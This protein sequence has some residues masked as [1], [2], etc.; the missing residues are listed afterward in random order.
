MDE[1]FETFF[2]TDRRRLIASLCAMGS[3][4]DTATEAVDEAFARAIERWSR[5]GSYTSASAWVFVTARNLVRR[6][7]R[8]RAHERRL[9]AAV[10]REPASPAPAGETWLVVAELPPRQ[11]EVVVLRHVAGLTEPAIGEALG[12][13]RGT[14]SST[15]R[16]AYAALARQLPDDPHPAT[17]R[18][19]R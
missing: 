4:L 15:S 13:S 8:R 10:A 19:T 3:D 2:R 18:G 6:R 11:Q 7:Q 12:I 14:V 1:E 16:D 17:P 5:V 9:L